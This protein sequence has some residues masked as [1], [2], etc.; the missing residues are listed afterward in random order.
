[1]ISV[2]KP[3]TLTTIQSRPRSNLR[4][5]GVPSGGAA[6]PL[7]LALANRLLGNDWDAP[8]LETTLEDYDA[9]RKAVGEITQSCDACHE[10]YR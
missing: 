5:R 6:D 8:A 9:V 7:S 10:Q 4:H 1:M 3:G 2:I